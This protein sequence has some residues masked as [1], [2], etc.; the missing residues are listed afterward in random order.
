MNGVAEACGLSK[1]ALYHYFRDKYDLLV[2]IAENHVVRLQTLVSEV[3]ELEPGAR[4]AAC[5]SSF[6][7]S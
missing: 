2:N 3:A 7:A 6:G 5:V 1:P 4:A